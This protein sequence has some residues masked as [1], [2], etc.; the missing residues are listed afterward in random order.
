MSK[1]SFSNIDL[2]LFEYAE[3]NLS[4]DQMAKLELF[5]LQHP[6]LDIDRDMWDMAKVSKAQVEY[7]DEASLY[8]SAPA[9]AFWGV[10]S[11]FAL[12]ISFVALNPGYYTIETGNP[13]PENQTQLSSVNGALH[14]METAELHQ[15]IDDLNRVIASLEGQLK[16]NRGTYVAS[17]VTMEPRT[18]PNQTT[19][20][21]TS[22]IIA[23]NQ[24]NRTFN[25]LNVR[26]NGSSQV[27][28]LLN[29]ATT[30]SYLNSSNQGIE[31][32]GHYL[33][34]STTSVE[35]FDDHSAVAPIE[36]VGEE[37]IVPIETAQNDLA[38]EPVAESADL[39]DLNLPEYFSELNTAPTKSTIANNG[40]RVNYE[41]SYR[42]KMSK[43]FRDLQR[44]MDNPIAL[45]NFRDP[46][47]HV[48]G[49]TT[50]DLNF[51]STGTVIAPR[52]QTMTRLQWL[53]QSN[54]MFSNQIAVDGYSYALRGGVGVQMS[55]DYYN[56]G[57][58]QDANVAFTYSP[59]IS[60]NRK[61]S[62]EPAVR[63][64]IGN[65]ML[66]ASQMEGQSSVEMLRGNTIDYYT[67]GSA[68][69]G[70][71]LWYKDMGLGLNVNTEWFYASAQVDNIFRYK[72]NMYSADLTDKRRAGTHFVAT[73]GTDWESKRSQWETQRADFGLSPYLVY[74]KFEKVNELW[75]GANFRCYWFTV[76][77]AVSTNLEPAASLGMKFKHFSLLY[78]ADYLQSTMTGKRSLSHQLTLKIVG[79]PNRNGQRFL[80]P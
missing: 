26:S 12:L 17:N 22:T 3:G 66:N 37:V 24:N 47:Y 1:P 5:V 2:W 9:A 23:S 35:D 29:S 4:P 20:S 56:Q 72:D 78:N 30:T 44:M 63:F 21:Q 28:T 75:A 25:G 43:M 60:I 52:V 7:P 6:E 41:N 8:R 38:N 67:D 64:K 46:S 61:I 76:G 65:K 34:Q 74:Q 68:P 69:V 13:T 55:H 51:G 57:G 45:K 54:E 16:G 77:A 36:T 49:A 80:N 18:A 15:E 39:E 32:S 10:G 14:Q 33:N 62:V 73:I 70:R 11:V 50:T 58:L 42:Y 53:G 19:P 40:V 31:L 71:F 48:P 79:K 27:P 59:K